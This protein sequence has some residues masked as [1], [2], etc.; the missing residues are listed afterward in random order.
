MSLSITCSAQNQVP[1]LPQYS[2]QTRP[3]PKVHYWAW[4]ATPVLPSDSDYLQVLEYYFSWPSE[5]R[6]LVCRLYGD[7]PANECHHWWKHNKSN[8]KLKGS[9]VSVKHHQRPCWRLIGPLKREPDIQEAKWWRA[10]KYSLV[11]L[12]WKQDLNCWSFDWKFIMKD[13]FRY[14]C[15]ILQQ[16]KATLLRVLSH[17]PVHYRLR[18]VL[19]GGCY[20][21]P[22]SKFQILT[23]KY[24]QK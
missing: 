2:H 4:R 8:I 11:V 22:K 21:L 13:R 14:S 3:S 19:V 1:L 10:E 12:S 24:G 17:T 16:R 23:T 7:Y 6:F 20:K 18:R 5:C 15:N 9:P